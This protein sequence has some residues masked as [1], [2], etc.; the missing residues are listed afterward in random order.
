MKCP[1]A[2][3]RHTVSQTIFEYDEDGKQTFRQTT[4]RNTAKFVDCL[5]GNCGAWR[6]GRCQ[7]NQVD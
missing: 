4:E 6:D 7:Y 1:Y 3:S 2:V 5:E